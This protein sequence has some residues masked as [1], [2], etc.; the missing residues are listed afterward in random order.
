M[1]QRNRNKYV[2]LKVNG[3]LFPTW[4]MANFS[5][6]KLDT[7][8]HE[9][10]DKTVDPC[11][12]IKREKKLREYQ[13]FAGK[14]LDFNGPYKDILLYHGL[15]S[16]KTATAVNIYNLLY[17]STP[18]WNVFI[19]LKATLKNV[20]WIQ[21]LDEWLQEEDKKYRYNNIKFISYDAPN[22]DKAFMDAVKNADTSKKN[23]YFIEEAHNFIRNVYSNISSTSGKRAQTI[24]DYIIQDKKENDSVRV[25]LLTATPAINKPFEVAL[26]FNL[27][28]PNIFP[29]SEALFNEYF[30]KTTG[31]GLEQLNP[32][33]KNTFQR[34]ILGLV[35]YYVGTTPDF[36]AR[37][38]TH[39]IDVIMSSYQDDI[40]N[41]FQEIEDKLLMK[42][43]GKSQTYMSY[44][45][46]AANFVFPA[47]AQ[48]MTGETRPRPKNFKLVDDI[49]KGK[50]LQIKKDDDKYYNVQSYLEQVAKFLIELEKYFDNKL[51]K[52]FVED[53]QNIREKYD[54]DIKKYYD[55][56]KN[57]SSLFTALY[58]C[59]PKYMC[60]IFNVLKS[61]GPTL[62]YTNYVLMEGV[63]IFKLYLKYFGFVSYQEKEG[64]LNGIDDFRF[65]EYHGGIDKDMRSVNLRK[66]NVSENKNGSKCKI[67]I[68]SAAGAEGLSL[69]NIRQVHI[70]EPYWNEV[71]IK[72][73]IGRAVRFCSHVDLPM[74]ERH[75]NIYR[76]KSVR[77][78]KNKK[79]TADQT[80]EELARGKEGL[81]VSFEDAIKEVAIDCEL[82]K[83]HN[84]LDQ[85][86]KCFK[87]DEND[88]FD[89]QIGPAYKEDIK[90]DFKIN[91]GSN[92]VNSV[93]I[94]IKVIKIKA[95]MLLDKNKD[96][97]KD[98]NTYSEPKYYWYNPNTHIVYDLDLHYAIGK[99][100]V[101][102][103][104]IPT[105]LTNEVYIIDKIIPIPTI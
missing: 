4:I 5:K 36:F 69:S 94:R 25:I 80:I 104:N 48:G 56:Y 46:Q 47:M 84:L 37:K 95:V 10:K 102:I 71:R 67:M 62:V 59:S 61:P 99:V 6:Y 1:S 23:L 98:L 40:Y 14:Y 33:T 60:V 53:I 75:V 29:K 30:V 51:D 90:D 12:N 21:H 73:M 88:L 18:G 83:G 81:I 3:K 34:R 41:Y 17:N 19:L 2:D 45:R 79:Q 13:T 64:K 77:I 43:K 11:L 63:Q 57:K 78:D 50:E 105:K 16:G 101:D 91:S 28:R 87:F 93:T 7:I 55:E 22:A 89:E 49:D 35:S 9:D 92:A 44:T 65:L 39:Y 74:E 82:F 20:P 52:H 8:R 86:Y 103:D 54:Y 58:D 96:G 68:I 97:D 27:L 24:Y 85:D 31:L 70:I 72:Q 38:T 66:F 26:L 100:G 32:L 15:G 76:Y 42:S